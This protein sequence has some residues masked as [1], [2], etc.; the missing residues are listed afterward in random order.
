M[1]QS[2][3]NLLRWVAILPGAMLGGFLATFPLH[4]VLYFTLANGEIISGV[5]I[6]PIEYTFYPFVIAITFVLIGSKIAPNHKFKTAVVLTCLWIASFIALFLFM[7]DSQTQFGIRG[8]G[9][10]LGS[11][12]GLFIVWKK[13]N[14][15]PSAVII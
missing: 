11:L 12:L 7:P 1:Q 14:H 9:S 10:L 2:T 15:N 6:G 8:V 4:W 5:N 3:K 13:F